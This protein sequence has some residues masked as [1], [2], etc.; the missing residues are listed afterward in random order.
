MTAKLRLA[1]FD[2]HPQCSAC[3]FSVRLDVFRVTYFEEAHVNAPATPLLKITCP[4][5][6]FSWRMK[7]F[8]REDSR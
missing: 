3:G 5:C 7:T 4:R 1:E 6:G 2:S 8:M